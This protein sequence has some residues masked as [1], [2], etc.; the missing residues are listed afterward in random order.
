M[1]NFFPCVRCSKL[2]LVKTRTIGSSAVPETP[3]LS[4]LHSKPYLR[5]LLSL[6]VVDPIIRRQA[7][8]VAIVPYRIT[9][10]V[11]AATVMMTGAVV[12]YHVTRN[13]VPVATR[14][15]RAVELIPHYLCQLEDSIVLQADLVHHVVK[16]KTIQSP[17]RITE[18]R[19]Q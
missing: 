16:E 15:T 7:N 9:A 6:P 14:T 3:R 19:H 18:T 1:I 10:G 8:L 5:V 2:Q 17:L 13:K 4:W 12:Q 11:L